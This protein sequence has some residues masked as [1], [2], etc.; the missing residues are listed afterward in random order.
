MSAMHQFENYPDQQPIVPATFWRVQLQPATLDQLTSLKKP[1]KGVGHSQG[2]EQNMPPA[3]D[4]LDEIYVWDDRLPVLRFVE[5]NRLRG[6]L[7]EARQALDSAFGDVAIRTLSLVRD[8]EGFD[9][10][11]CLVRTRSELEVA[12]RAL[13]EFDEQWWLQHSGEAHGNLNFDFDLV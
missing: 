6:L 1:P 4:P 7:L 3:A 2:F 10:L 5:E 13:Q 11:F 12:N 9:T 8:D